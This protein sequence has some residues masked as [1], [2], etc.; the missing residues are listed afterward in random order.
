MDQINFNTEKKSKNR[1][2]NKVRKA[3]SNTFHEVETSKSNPLLVFR[4]STD[5]LLNSVFN[6]IRIKNS[7]YLQ[8]LLG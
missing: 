4:T 1:N 6:D 3:T 5:L 2:K 7:C 8:K